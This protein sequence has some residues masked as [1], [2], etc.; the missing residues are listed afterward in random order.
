MKGHVTISD[1]KTMITIGDV[2]PLFFDTLKYEYA[3][4][5]SFRQCFDTSD[6]ILLQV[7][8]DGG[9][10]PSAY[11]IDQI[12]GS[13]EEIDFR[14]YQVKDG[15]VMHYAMMYP[16]EGVYSIS[17]NK[18]HSEVFEV[19]ENAAG[20]LV[21]Y[22][23]K[24]NNSVFDNIFWDGSTQFVFNLRICGGVKPSGV[25]IEIDN[26]QFVNQRQ[27]IVELYAVPYVTHTFS[28][29]GVEGVPYYMAELLNKVFCLSD[30]KIDGK[31][32]VREGNSKPEKVET[33][34]RKELFLWTMNLRPS[35]NTIAGIGGKIE[36]GTSASIVGFSINNPS[37]GEVLVYN[38]E[39][40]AFVN[41]NQLSSI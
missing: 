30:V 8:C 39:E 10:K 40:S 31:G 13:S 36:E 15:V 34:G 7:F 38:A 24:D 37:D 29:G 32:Y 22:T 9:E 27:E 25:N 2:C 11:L 16:E 6:G 17:L 14:T 20:M 5:G 21:E 1:E 4:G 3:N 23:H 41:T 19:C 35:E 26:E 18:M 12:D 33:L 28:I